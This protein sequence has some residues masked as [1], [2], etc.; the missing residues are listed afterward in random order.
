MY[1]KG[2]RIEPRYIEEEIKDSYITYAMSVIAGRALPDAR[3]GLKPVHRRILYTMNDLSLQHSKPYKKSA[4]I[5]GSCLGQF[6]PHGDMAVY[7]ALVRMVQE[8]SLR[9]PLVDG[10]GNFGSVDGD[11]AAAMR[12][13]EA[14]MSAPAEEMLKDI[15]KDTVDFSP[16]FDDTLQEPTVLPSVLPNLL[17]NGSSGIAVGMATNM[18][19]HNLGEIIDGVVKVIDEP[20]VSIEGLMKII[21]GPDFPTGALI[22]GRDGIKQAHLTG[23]GSLKLHARASI[24]TQKNN[25]E[26]IIVSELPYQVNKAN[27]IAAIARLVGERKLEGISDIRDESDKDGMRIVIDI[28]RDQPAQVVLNQLYKHTQ[29]STTFGVIMLAL[30]HNQPRV[31]NLRQL[32]DVFIDHRKEVVIRRTKFELAKA[33]ARAHILEGLKIALKH[34]DK[35]IKTIKASKSTDEARKALVKNFDLSEKQAQAILEMQLQRLTA[36]ERS[37]IEAEYL[38][39]LKKIE[40][41]QSILKSEKKILGIIKDELAVIRDKYA[42]ERRTEIVAA[43]QDLEIEDLIAEEDMVITISHAGYIKRLPISSYK[44]QRRGG[45]GITAAGLKEEDFIEYLFIASTH[46][47]ILFFTDQGKCYWLKVHTIPQGGR[48][49]KGKAIVNLIQLTKDENITAFVP[50]RKFDDAFY[51][52]MITKK[53]NV[54]RANLSAFSNPR[55]A[56]IVAITLDKD[57]VLIQVVLTDGK[58]EIVIASELGKALRFKEANVREMGR[59]ARGVRGISL[60][61]K[62]SVIGMEIA[63]TDATLLT[64]TKKGF[65]KRSVLSE[66]RTQS[67]GGKGIINLKI[68]AKNGAVIG[69]KSVKDGDEVMIITS[70][71]MIV[72]TPVKNIRATGRSTQGVK[73]IALKDKDTVSAIANVAAEEKEQISVTPSSSG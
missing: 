52:A 30:V 22:C 11:S 71:G 55:K 29:L 21:K 58:Q 59:G 47:Y 38:E 48:A 70:Q 67:R 56:G 5:V 33:Q 46:E 39:L 1:A 66:Y 36:L 51:L 61:A 12:Y 7:D 44:R 8:F 43:E 53:G 27:L 20:N 14:R 50:V 40:Y 32:I 63:R 64:V 3:D 28:K 26:S 2:E 37:K 15:D 54:K 41:Y 35:I 6:H 34:I 69:I 19:P 62:D 24:E 4:R 10:Q 49:S 72:R 16:N 73:L 17:I 13:T 31:L 42:D 25:R 57:D 18:P 9:Y 60:G 45:K 68:S 23:R 65:G